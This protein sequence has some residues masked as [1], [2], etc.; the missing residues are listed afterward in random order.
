MTVYQFEPHRKR[1]EEQAKEAAKQEAAPSK[2]TIKFI[3]LGI[4]VAVLA[5]GFMFAPGSL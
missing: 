3:G 1:R 4:G 5:L 2:N